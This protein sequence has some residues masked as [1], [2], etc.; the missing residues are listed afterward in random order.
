MLVMIRE[1]LIFISVNREF[2]FLILVN[3][4]Q[5]PH[6]PPPPTLSDPLRSTWTVC[7]N[8]RISL[9]MTAHATCMIPD[10]SSQTQEASRNLETW[11]VKNS[12]E[13]N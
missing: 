11:A 3:C 9:L 12:V 10:S 1:M 6:P 13:L 7:K 5:D 4:G 8:L 2:L